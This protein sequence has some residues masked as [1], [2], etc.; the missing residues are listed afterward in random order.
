MIQF[1]T[2][3]AAGVE[4][5]IKFQI[6]YFGSQYNKNI[7][8]LFYSRV[9]K[10]KQSTSF[11]HTIFNVSDVQ[12]NHTILYFENLNLNGNLI[13]GLGDPVHLDSA[14]NKKYVDIENSRQDIAIADKASKSYVDG[15]IARVHIDTTPLFPRDGSR[16]MSGDLD[17]ST[18]HILS[19]ENLNDYKVDDAYEVRVKDLKSV[20]NKEYLNENFL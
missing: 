16:S 8:F 2:D 11:D 14:T 7:K 17:M 15:E 9:I 13:D 3:G 18:N 20:V 12:D 1:T 10:G 5:G 6:K 4:D 19:V